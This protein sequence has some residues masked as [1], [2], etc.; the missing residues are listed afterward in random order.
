MTEEIT[1]YA[2]WAEF[3]KP[4]EIARKLKKLRDFVGIGSQQELADRTGISR[5]SIAKIEAGGHALR[6]AD[7]RATLAKGLGVTAAHFD[8]YLC[9]KLSVEQV[10]I[11]AGHER[12]KKGTRVPEGPTNDL[13]PDPL[14]ARLEDA[15]VRAFRN[16]RFGLDALDRV[17]S[18][19]PALAAQP[20]ESVLATDD[21]I[22]S[23]VQTLLKSSQFLSTDTESKLRPETKPVFLLLRAFVEL[24]LQFRA[25]KEDASLEVLEQEHFRAS[26]HARINDEQRMTYAMLDELG[27]DVLLLPSFLNLPRND[28]N[29]VMRYASTP[30]QPEF[31]R[32]HQALKPWEIKPRELTA[33]LEAE[34]Q[35]LDTPEEDLVTLELL[36]CPRPHG[37]ALN[38]R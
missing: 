27:K 18:I 28:W 34:L 29:L 11:H 1:E 15:L 9:G 7:L 22:S 25:R 31:E 13:W 12:L 10:A 23:L 26:I 17:R 19:L 21:S 4:Q 20:N 36:G 30:G 5:S 2:L 32:V 14:T 35:K 6:P 33:T 37:A 16:G 38:D 3:P 8:A 24:D